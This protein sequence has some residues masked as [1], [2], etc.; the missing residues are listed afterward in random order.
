M[1]TK[2]ILILC[3]FVSL[4]V[5]SQLGGTTAAPGNGNDTYTGGMTGYN[6]KLPG[7]MVEKK[8]FP[9]EIISMINDQANEFIAEFNKRWKECTK[10]NTFNG[11]IVDL[12]YNLRKIQLNQYI[13]QTTNPSVLLGT[14][15][16]QKQPCQCIEDQNPSLG[17]S[18]SCLMNETNR[19][20]VNSFAGNTDAELKLFMGTFP[21][22]KPEERLTIFEFFKQLSKDYPDSKRIE[23]KK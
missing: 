6:G 19:M 12:Y 18:I 7:P 22:T 20:L 23:A 13:Y 11:D 14:N 8:L 1:K 2:L 10:E 15:N 16:V 17:T 21:N 4:N 9:N 3:F 5:Y